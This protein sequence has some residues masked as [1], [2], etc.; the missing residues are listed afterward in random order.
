MNELFV[1]YQEHSTIDNTLGSKL[2]LWVQHFSV[3]D[4]MKHETE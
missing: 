3:R 1:F 2:L 4:H